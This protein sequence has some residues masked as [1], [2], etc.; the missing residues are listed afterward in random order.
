MYVFTHYSPGLNSKLTM[1]RS[2]SLY[3]IT[4]SHS[5]YVSQ[6]GFVCFTLK[7][8][9]YKGTN[10][11]LTLTVLFGLPTQNLSDWEKHWI[12]SGAGVCQSLVMPINPVWHLGPPSARDPYCKL[13]NFKMCINDYSIN[14][15]SVIVTVCNVSLEY[16]IIHGTV[17][18]CFLKTINYV[19]SPG[20]FLHA[21]IH[22]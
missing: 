10:V 11:F 9:S 5:H 18:F 22:H 20:F 19:S 14:G 15:C 7:S 17:L 1:H 13:W 3:L 4:N 8:Y 16:V 2:K 21:T 12:H 6:K